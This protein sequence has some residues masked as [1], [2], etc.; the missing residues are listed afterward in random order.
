MQ[1]SKSFTSHLGRLDELTDRQDYMHTFFD[2][3]LA[4]LQQ[5]EHVHVLKSPS[6]VNMMRKLSIIQDSRNILAKR[7]HDL[8]NHEDL[9]MDP[10]TLQE[11]H[12]IRMV[13]NGYL[14]SIW[15]AFKEFLKENDLNIYIDR[16]KA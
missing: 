7:G 1:N 16:R 5:P 14:D 11:I 10:E 2:I 3:L 4:T 9:E 12:F 8:C 13:D 15:D 6:Y